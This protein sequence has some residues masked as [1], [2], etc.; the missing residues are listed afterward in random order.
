ML[1]YRLWMKE[2]SIKKLIFF[3]ALTFLLHFLII[4]PIRVQVYKNVLSPIIGTYSS[5]VFDLVG[6]DLEYRGFIM[7]YFNQYRFVDVIVPFGA[8]FSIP[9]LF[10]FALRTKPLYKT[11]IFYHIVLYA[12]LYPL[13]LLLLTNFDALYFLF[14]LFQMATIF[15]GLTFC[16][17]G[18]RQSVRV[19]V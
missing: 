13:G 10:L 7:D 5:Y 6:V 16:I 12:I 3:L 11:F 14:N 18:F 4:E 15:L 8:V 9:F 1:N 2:K 19:N 17:I